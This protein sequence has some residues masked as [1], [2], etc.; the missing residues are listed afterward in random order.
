VDRQILFESRSNV[1]MVDIATLFG[2]GFLVVSL[3][4]TAALTYLGLGEGEFTGTRG[5]SGDEGGDDASGA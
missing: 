1:G 2:I 5:K 4:M 3:L